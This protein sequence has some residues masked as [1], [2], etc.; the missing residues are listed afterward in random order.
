MTFEVIQEHFSVFSET[1]AGRLV[2]SQ[3][4]H[5][6]VGQPFYRINLNLVIAQIAR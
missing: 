4:R 5:Q 1:P 2:L 6:N 3:K